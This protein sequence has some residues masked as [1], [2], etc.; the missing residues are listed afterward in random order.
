[1]ISPEDALNLGW[2]ARREK[3]TGKPAGTLTMPYMESR[4]ISIDEYIALV[5]RATDTLDAIMNGHPGVVIPHSTKTFP[6]PKMFA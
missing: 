4:G 5:R 6:P 2:L 3:E 1:M